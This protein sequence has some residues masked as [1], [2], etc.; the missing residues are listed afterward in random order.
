MSATLDSR[1]DQCHLTAEVAVDLNT[2][3]SKTQ[4]FFLN[5]NVSRWEPTQ[6]FHIPILSATSPLI[7]FGDNFM[8]PGVIATCITFTYRIFTCC[9]ICS[10]LFDFPLLFC[11]FLLHKTNPEAEN[12]FTTSLWKRNTPEKN[13]QHVKRCAT[14]YT[15]IRRAH[16][17]PLTHF[18]CILRW[19]ISR[20]S[21]GALPATKGQRPLIPPFFAHLAFPRGGGSYSHKTN[22]PSLAFPLAS[23]AGYTYSNH[24]VF[25][26]SLLNNSFKNR[27]HNSTT[28][29]LENCKGTSPV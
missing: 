16:F 15:P 11:R 27:V 10:L 3:S 19:A 5:V 24:Q 2:L 25:C 22:D 18:L 20:R 13:A 7:A 21:S 9:I 4:D 8:S 14:H 28:W 26:F 6:P 23:A 29:V 12:W 17:W 1:S